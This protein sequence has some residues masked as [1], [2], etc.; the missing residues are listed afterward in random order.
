M[1]TMY[2]LINLIIIAVIVVVIVIVI[3]K[4]T[5]ALLRDE[6]RKIVGGVALL[7]GVVLALYGIS[8]INSA[9]S[10]LARAMDK[11]DQSGIIAIGIGVMIGIIGIVILSSK[12]RSSSAS[13]ASTTRKCPF[14]AETIQAEAK[15]CRFCGKTLETSSTNQP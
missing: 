3:K 14:C 7:V 15:L 12:G 5:S 1:N 2:V 13:N 8:S 9:S 6:V 4:V 10:Q 11:P